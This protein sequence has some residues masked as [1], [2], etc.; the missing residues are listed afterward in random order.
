MRAR[1]DCAR[2]RVTLEEAFTA[3]ET[4]T[5]RRWRAASGAMARVPDRIIARTACQTAAAG[6]SACPAGL[7]VVERGCKTCRGSGEVISYRGK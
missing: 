4:I 7:L 3:R 2:S 5:A 1:R 6:E